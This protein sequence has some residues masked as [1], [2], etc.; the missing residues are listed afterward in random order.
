MLASVGLGFDF[1]LS[2][3]RHIPE[4]KVDSCSITYRRVDVVTN[5]R[6]SPA[7]EV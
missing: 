2:R 5:P 3:S 4:L 7:P 6:G 1:D